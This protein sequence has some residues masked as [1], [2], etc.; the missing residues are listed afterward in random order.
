MTLYHGERILKNIALQQALNGK[1]WK[2]WKVVEGRSNRKYTDETLVADTVKNAGFDPFEHKVLG[3][4]AMSKLLGKT[5]FEKLLGEL[6][7][8]PK[9]KPTLVPMSDKRP[10]MNKA[11]D[12]A[13][14]FKEEN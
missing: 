13:E 12:A 2:Y 6:I 7:E 5:K 1:E 9:G 10:A 3:I 8:K 4:T 11:A 14:D